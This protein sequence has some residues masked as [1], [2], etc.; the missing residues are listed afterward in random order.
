[1]RRGCPGIV[2]LP[3][4]L[5]ALAAVANAWDKETLDALAAVP[6]QDDGRVKPLSTYARFELLKLS[7]RTTC[8]DA[9]GRKMRAIQWLAD[10]LFFPKRAMSH[11]IFLIQS[12][13]VT[14]ALSL[15][16]EGKRVR[17]RYSFRELEPAIVKLAQLETEYS[18]IPV[19]ERSQTQNQLVNLAHNVYEAHLLM[20]YLDVAREAL[21]AAPERDAESVLV[22]L[23]PEL[24]GPASRA[25]MLALFPPSSGE[26]RETWLTAAD[27][28][29]G[30]GSQEDVALLASFM[31]LVRLTDNTGA[32]RRQLAAFRQ[33]VMARAEARG[34]GGH[35]QLEVLFYRL[36]LV[37]RSFIAYLVSFLLV[38]LSWL[39]PR[40]RWLSRLA[41]AALSVAVLLLVA[42][43]VLR[44]IIRGRPPV[45]TLYETILF[46]TAVAVAVALFIEWVNHRRIAL[47]V[48]TVLGVLGMF[49]A[50][51]YEAKEG[52]DT[53]PSMVAVLDTNFWLT[54]HVT[55]IIM[56]YAAGLL[57]AALGHVYVFGRVLR[58]R[59]KD[60]QLYATITRMT[61]GVLCFG[62]LFSITG[63]VLGGVWANESWGRFWGWDPKENGAL[64]ICLWLLALLHARAAGYIRELGL[65]VG[66]VF[67]GM[68]LAFSWWGVNLLGVGLHS[69]GFTSGTLNILIVFY[70]IEALVLWTGLGVWWRER[71]ERPTN[72]V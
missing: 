56:G 11:E 30:V 45:T 17:D 2:L 33:E 46:T 28:L 70:V 36:N 4:A 16:V 22:D 12:S 42:G 10:A 34:Q 24:F 23:P 44:C 69:Y 21:G 65:N 53:M 52:A 66:A 72:Q 7:G 43:I 1:M 50:N 39:A 18:T 27:V 71:R 38:A 3:L 62:L 5:L 63:T 64:M 25:V 19:D 29:T 54:M 35:I 6:V 55:T 31:A 13:A 67:G 49:L 68:V 20:A 61:Y 32:F 37:S 58:I 48:G 26:E 40:R 14:D 9:E 59:A 41:L 51:R 57:A 47:S 8:K 60:A 15:H